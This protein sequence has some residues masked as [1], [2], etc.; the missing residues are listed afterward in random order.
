LLLRIFLLVVL[1]YLFLVLL[2]SFLSWR[3]RGAG[4][5]GRGSS[6]AEEM[7]QDPQCLSYVPKGEAVLRGGNYFC[8]ER[9]ATLF[10][11]R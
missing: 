1:F 2:R 3:K 9:C 11:S 4:S 7:V 10:L 6:A 5:G 8:S